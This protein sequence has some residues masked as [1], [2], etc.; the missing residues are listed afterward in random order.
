M[1]DARFEFITEAFPKVAE[2]VASLAR[3][4]VYDLLAGRGDKV[5]EQLKGIVY[6]LVDTGAL[7]DADE[8]VGHAIL[9][10]YN[11]IGREQCNG[12]N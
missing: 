9:A 6:A 7:S 12:A 11:R 4:Y 10:E 5:G 8:Y 3:R 1:T 2:R